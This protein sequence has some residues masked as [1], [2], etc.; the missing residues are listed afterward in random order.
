MNYNMDPKNIKRTVRVSHE[1]L[2]TH[3]FDSPVEMDQQFGKKN[4]ITY[5]V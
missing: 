5:P 3:Q 2:F 4:Y 1:Q